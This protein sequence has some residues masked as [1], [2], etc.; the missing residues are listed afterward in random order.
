MKLFQTLGTAAVVGAFA[1][2]SAFAFDCTGDGQC[3]IILDGLSD[4]C[5][6][7]IEITTGPLTG[8]GPIQL[9]IC[10]Y[11][12]LDGVCFDLEL[13]PGGESFCEIAQERVGG[14]YRFTYSSDV[15]ATVPGVPGTF[16]GP[17]PLTLKSVNISP[18]PLGEDPNP[19]TYQVVSDVHLQNGMGNE[20]ILR[21]GSSVSIQTTKSKIICNLGNGTCEIDI[22]GTPSLINPIITI[23]SEEPTPAGNNTKIGIVTAKEL[24]AQGG[25]TLVLDPQRAPDESYFQLTPVNASQDFPAQVNGYFAAKIDVNGVTY[26]SSDVLSVESTFPVNEWPPATGT[27]EYI[28]SQPIQFFS[29]QGDVLTIHQGHVTN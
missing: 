10:D 8:S 9:A 6:T 20:L 13:P 22:N 26:R 24:L 15:Q 27:A 3:E 11:K 14:G 12:A 28:L 4:D 7:Q 19:V 29:D 2:A 23:E 1:A 16:T 21:Q 25:F 5:L 18:F 17:D